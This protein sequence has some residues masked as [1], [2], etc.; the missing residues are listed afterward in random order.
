VDLADHDEIAVAFRFFAGGAYTYGILLNPE[1]SPTVD[2]GVNFGTDLSGPLP[3]SIGG[4]NDFELRFT[5]QNLRRAGFKARRY[6]L[7][8]KSMQDVELKE[9][10]EP[11]KT[12]SFGKGFDHNRSINFENLSLIPANRLSSPAFFRS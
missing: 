8:A 7:V 4:N 1:L 11:S 3:L 9:R 12:A 2:R 10:V 5:G 6:R